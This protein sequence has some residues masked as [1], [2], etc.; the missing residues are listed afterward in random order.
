MVPT[1]SIDCLQRHFLAVDLHLHDLASGD[2]NIDD[3]LSGVINDDHH[4]QSPEEN[5]E[6]SEKKNVSN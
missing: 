1:P 6:D 5:I 4:S 3:G 2:G